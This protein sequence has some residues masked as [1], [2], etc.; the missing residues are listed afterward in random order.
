MHPK[1]VKEISQLI[2]IIVVWKDKWGRVAKE[3]A[4]DLPQFWKISAFIELCPPGVQ[5]MIHQTVDEVNE[6]YEKVKQ[7]VVSW[8]ANKSASGPT[9]MDIG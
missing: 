8:V 2:S 5:D 1:P 9:P 3:H 7:R 6:N 4:T